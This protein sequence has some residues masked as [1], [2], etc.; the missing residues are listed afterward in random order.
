M[1]DK[2]TETCLF[3]RDSPKRTFFCEDIVSKS[4]MWTDKRKAIL[5]QC[6]TRWAIRH[7]AYSHF[8]TSYGFTVKAL[9]VIAHGLHR[10]EVSEL[11]QD[12]W[13][14]SSRVR[15]SAIHQS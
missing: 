13:D 14:P 2:L 4:V 3:F 6:K 9:E 15:A 12:G 5:D 8:Y 11:F 10:E 7:I 1:L